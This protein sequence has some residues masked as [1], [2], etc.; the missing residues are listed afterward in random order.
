MTKSFMIVTIEAEMVG[1]AA[2]TLPP[3]LCE[4]ELDGIGSEEKPQAG[5]KS[6]Q[7][8]ETNEGTDILPGSVA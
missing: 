6:V 2:T 4:H 7:K 3:T 1:R 8:V 5:N